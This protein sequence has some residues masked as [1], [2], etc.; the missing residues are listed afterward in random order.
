[1]FNV[2]RRFM[3]KFYTEVEYKKYLRIIVMQI[4]PFVS[5]EVNSLT[6][7]FQI[8][9]CSFYKKSKKTLF[10]SITNASRTLLKNMNFKYFK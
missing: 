8:T 3:Y 6:I 10:T 5:Y 9:R 4:N 2:K 7:E 1:M